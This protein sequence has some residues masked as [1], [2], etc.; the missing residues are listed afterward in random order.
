MQTL[1]HMYA[2]HSGNDRLVFPL[3]LVMWNTCE[4]GCIAGTGTCCLFQF[5]LGSLSNPRNVGGS[6]LP[7]L[8]QV[9]VVKSFLLHSTAW[10]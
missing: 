1:W 2:Q 3:K 10:V 5:S 4:E 7:K 8:A 6:Y 9:L